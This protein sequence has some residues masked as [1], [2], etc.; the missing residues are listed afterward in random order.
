MSL[1][2]KLLFPTLVLALLPV[3]LRAAAPG[4]NF[5]HYGIDEGLSQNTV[6]S[7]TQDASGNMW[8]ATYDGVDRFDGYHFRSYRLDSPEE[9]TIPGHMDISLFSDSKGNVWASS[10][11]LYKYDAQIDSFVPFERLKGHIVRGFAEYLP[12]ESVLFQTDKGI[13]P[14][15]LRDKDEPLNFLSGVRSCALA[16][17]GKAV[18]VCTDEGTAALYVDGVQ[19]WETSFPQA[20]QAKDILIIG[21]DRILVA[22]DGSGLFFL[23]GRTVKCYRHEAG[24]D[25]SLCSNYVRALSRDVNGNVWVGTG[26]G[27]S[28][29]NLTDGSFSDIRSNVSVKDIFNDSAGN[30]WLGTYYG[31]VWYCHP[32]RSFFTCHKLSEGRI[33]AIGGIAEDSDG[34]LWV[35]TGRDGL[36]RYYPHTGASERVSL[37]S[38]A[39]EMDDIK[40]ICFSPDGDKMFLG[41]GLGGLIVY[42]RQNKTSVRY[43]GGSCPR[44][45][46]S[47]LREG[48][49]YLWLG[50]LSGLYLFDLKGGTAT[51]VHLVSGD[52]LFIYSLF[53][54]SAGKIWLGAE[55][56]LLSCRLSVRTGNSV[57]VSE[58]DHYDK[59]KRVQDIC[60][61][62][63]E[64]WVATRDGLYRRPAGKGEWLLYGRKDGLSSDIIRGLEPDRMG[65]LWIGTENGLDCLDPDSG[66]IKRFYEED[67]LPG[68]VM[69]IYAH[70]GTSSGKVWFGGLNGLFSFSPDVDVMQKESR[71]PVVSAV[72]VDGEARK[73]GE[74]ITLRHSQKS[75]TLVFAVPNYS[76]WQKDVFRYRLVGA[77]KDWETAGPSHSVSYSNLRPGRY[78]FELVSENADGVKSQPFSMEITVLA[79]WYLSKVAFAVYTILFFLMLAFLFSYLARKINERRLRDIEKI[80]NL[81]REELDRQ[82]ALRFAGGGGTKSREDIDFLV[83]VLNDVEKNISDDKYGVERLASD[84]CMSRSNL[85]LRVRDITGESPLDFIRR[86]R[87]EKACDLLRETDKPIAEIGSLVGFS[88]PSY[89]SASFKKFTGVLPGSF[90]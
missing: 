33:S 77:Q 78:C 81:S 17:S 40:A 63:S 66:R 5:M 49:R 69:G 27:L 74:E 45:V 11:I 9:S 70:C 23:D 88:S 61:T 20:S 90:R 53:R 52:N 22:T 35:G 43:L 64:M 29:M 14:L 3:Q 57:S 86:V 15:S 38:E 82:R 54:D 87:M 8:F 10:G 2:S 51:K 72:I 84:M 25:G 24:R 79:V 56:C 50:T 68:N 55:S 18:A 21:E 89:F 12:E 28:I 42:S 47:I 44:S 83:K 4:M 59:I 48:E 19:L 1:K 30:V 62:G 80:K 36:Y 31:G 67:G 32:G 71:V 6:F 73:L 76:S 41:T 65:R 16:S 34:T 46:Y 26:N 39:A 13:V 60:Q 75:L 58:I 85:Y 37:P 7:V